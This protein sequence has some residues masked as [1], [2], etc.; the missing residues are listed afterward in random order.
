MHTSVSEDGRL[1]AIS[2]REL[3]SDVIGR[4]SEVQGKFRTW[5]LILSGLS[6]LGVIGFIIR[7]NDGFDDRSKWGY[8]AATLA[9]IT[10]IFVAAPII[11]IGQ[12]YIISQPREGWE[13]GDSP[14]INEGPEAIVDPNGQLHIVYSAN[15]SWN[16]KYCLA[17]LRL[18]K[19]GNPTYVWDW[20]KS[21]G[22]LFGSHQD[23]MMNGWDATLY[24]D[25]PGHHTFALTDGDALLESSFAIAG[26]HVQDASRPGEISKNFEI[27]FSK[28]GG[29]VPQE[30]QPTLPKRLFW[31]SK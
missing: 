22:C 18:R 9:Y 17:D 3:T 29:V 14:A 12:R 7:L 26:F 11:S 2:H 15:G 27:S 5:I 6:L 10:T 23:R 19:G 24:I 31:Q 25:G 30:T 28:E 13:K 20:Y 21:N 16:N 8:L 1:D 4:L